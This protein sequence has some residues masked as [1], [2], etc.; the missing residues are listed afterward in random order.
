[1][2]VYD[3]LLETVAGMDEEVWRHLTTPVGN[4]PAALDAYLESADRDAGAAW[5]ALCGEAI[6]YIRARRLSERAGSAAVPEAPE[7]VSPMAVERRRFEPPS[8]GVPDA[9]G[10]S[11]ADILAGQACREDD[12]IKAQTVALYAAW[13]VENSD[14]FR[15]MRSRLL[16]GKTVGESSLLPLLASP[17][18]RVL[19]LQEFEAIGIPTI[20]AYSGLEHDE[21]VP[22][23]DGQRRWTISFDHYHVKASRVITPGTMSSIRSILPDD[24]LPNP[25]SAEDLLYN[26]GSVL[27]QLL[28]TSE[29]LT[30]C[31]LHCSLASALIFLLTG[32]V[33]VMPPVDAK[34]LH[35]LT[36][37]GDYS[38]H[39][40]GHPAAST[41]GPVWRPSHVS[42]T[43]PLWLSAD[44]AEQAFR[45]VQREV[46]GAENRPFKPHYVR[47]FY[48]VLR[49]RRRMGIAGS[50][51]EAERRRI[52]TRWNEICQRTA[53]DDWRQI[54]REVMAGNMPNPLREL[55]PS[56]AVES[57]T[58]FNT[59]C[60]RI[61]ER[62]FPSFF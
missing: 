50:G 16:A 28:E 30:S 59:T 9:E 1:M 36:N 14:W 32:L 17:G 48:F 62:V 31:L 5:V 46:L 18:V 44:V 57:F 61:E 54:D 37:G 27:G 41:F 55:D 38:Y 49:E 60:N 24:L 51:T 25:A 56:W 8:S 47:M 20:D 40:T 52:W 6:L 10:V 34:W 12:L 35:S 13:R 3:E 43:F 42:L 29:Y 39:L 45:K 22:G 58:Y 7:G 53:A 11:D 26:Q 2:A 33:P 21:P 19:S 15:Q 4:S 23:H